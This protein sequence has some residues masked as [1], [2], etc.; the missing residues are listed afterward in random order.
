MELLTIGAFARATRLSPKALR[1]YDELGLLTPA[2]VD[3]LSGYRLYAPEQLDRARLVA[4]LRRLGMPPARIRHVCALDP[5]EA[6]GEVRAYWAEVE[7]DTAARR[8]LATFLVDQLSGEDDTMTVAL[9]YSLRTDR[10][11]VRESN[12]YA[13]YAG[14][15]VLAVADGFGARGE[16][17]STA[18]VAALAALDTAVPAGELLN[19]LSDAVR[20]A[21]DAVGDHLSADPV[22]GCTGT[23]LTALVLSGSRLGLVHVGDARA[24]LL[25]GGGLFRITH[26]HTVVRSL[27][28]E[29]RLTEEEALTHP[30]RAMLVRALTGREVEPDLALHDALPGDRYL[31]CTDGLHTVVRQDDLRDVLTGSAHP[32]DATR[33]LVELANAGGGPDNVVC[34]VADVVAA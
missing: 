23:T 7:A 12:Q 33:R 28:A 25:R 31:L 19:A 5:A 34:V 2:R 17:L 8:D 15:R 26:D 1:L 18:A 10:G 30:Q 16:P 3:P 29:G 20:R 13:G 4:W 27:I 9:R 6:A 11:L 14:E 22:D 21:G 24:Y 32:D